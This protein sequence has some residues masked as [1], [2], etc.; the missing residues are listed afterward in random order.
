MCWKSRAITVSAFAACLRTWNTVCVGQVGH[1]TG[2]VVRAG[3]AKSPWVLRDRV[4]RPIKEIANPDARLE[5]LD[6]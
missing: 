6:R 1:A 3:R 2:T 4:G 5:V